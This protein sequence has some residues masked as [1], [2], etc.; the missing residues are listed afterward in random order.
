MKIVIAPDSFKGSLTALEAG[1]TIQ[2]AILAE[3][4]NVHIDV[5]PMADGG[6]GTLETLI[7]ATKG[8]RL[9]IEVTGPLGEK[10]STEYGVLGDGKTVVIEMANIAGLPMVPEEERNPLHTTTYGIGETI[11]KATEL[12]HRRFIIGLG[13]SAT[14]DGG[15][16]MLQALGVKFLD[17]NGTLV[18]CY[19]SDVQK[20][21]NVDFSS[22]NP[23]ISECSFIIASDVNNPL[24]GK[25]GASHVFGPQKGASIQVVEALD[26]ALSSY[27]TVIEKELGKSYQHITGAGAAGG[28]GFAFLLLGG[29]MKV[30]SEI[31]AD[32]TRLKEK[33]KNADW[34]ITGEGQSDFQTLFGKVPAF[35]ANLARENRSKTVLVSGGL[36]EGSEKLFD[37]FDCCFSIMNRPMTVE[38]AMANAKQLL[39]QQ[40]RNIARFIRIT[41]N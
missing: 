1:L 12:G 10:I 14:N 34:V 9:Q 3:L 27:A 11:L 22:I 37:L 16:G 39:Y 2:E 15:L 19:G 31:V 30:G 36:G 13:G 20:V 21:A 32:A 23:V 18:G 28:L 40:A 29:E 5:I 35:I 38:D 41:Q 33:I 8:K 25:T 4:P 7:F 26:T 17:R 24:C 6:E